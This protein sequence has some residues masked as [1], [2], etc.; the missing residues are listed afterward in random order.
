[1]SELAIRFRI[2][3]SGRDTLGVVALKVDGGVWDV[4]QDIAPGSASL[5]TAS[6]QKSEDQ[7]EVDI[8]EQGLTLWTWSACDAISIERD[9]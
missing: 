3:N 4:S 2:T 7:F 9:K 1:M 6:G 5:V 8:D